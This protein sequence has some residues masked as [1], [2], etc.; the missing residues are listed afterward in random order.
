MAKNVDQPGKIIPAAFRS[1]RT[2]SSRYIGSSNDE[3]LK[4]SFDTSQGRHMLFLKQFDQVL[5]VLRKFSTFC[6]SIRMNRDA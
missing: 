4:N 2:F 1:I 3:C 5:E 6:D